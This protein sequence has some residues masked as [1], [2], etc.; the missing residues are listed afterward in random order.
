MVTIGLVAFDEMFEIVKLWLGLGQRRTM[1]LT[2]STH[3][4]SCTY[5]DKSYYQRLG[6]NLQNFP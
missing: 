1:T 4:S 6:Q 3:K 2:S 5:S